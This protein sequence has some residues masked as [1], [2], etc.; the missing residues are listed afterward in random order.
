MYASIFIENYAK[1]MAFKEHEIATSMSQ[2]NK[3][4]ENKGYKIL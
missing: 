3:I 1:N 4:I 2:I